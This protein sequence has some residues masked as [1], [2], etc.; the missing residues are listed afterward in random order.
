MYF[1]L[2][3][4]TIFDWS[5]NISDYNSRFHSCSFRSRGYMC[6]KRSLRYSGSLVIWVPGFITISLVV[7]AWKN[8]FIH[9]SILTTFVFIMCYVLRDLIKLRLIFD[10]FWRHILNESFN[11]NGQHSRFTIYWQTSSLRYIFT[12][13][14][15]KVDLVKV[16]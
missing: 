3:Y 1:I 7:S 12:M 8:H 4:T 14:Q 2:I 16:N 6:I 11:I 9:P 13:C 10:I 5:K 15:T